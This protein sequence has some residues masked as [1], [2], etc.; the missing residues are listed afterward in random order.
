MK[1]ILV[2]TDFS[3]EADNAMDFAMQLALK[4]DAEIE[5]LHVLE[6]PSGSFSG[7]A[8]VVSSTDTMEEVYTLQLLR[9]VKQ[10]L[11]DREAQIQE[12]GVKVFTKMEKGSV[13]QHIHNHITD[14]DTDLI[15]MG[16]K[17]ATG[18]KEIFV[19]SNTERVIRHSSV[20]VFTVKEKIS[21]D[22]FRNMVFAVGECTDSSI[23]VVKEFQKLLGLNCHLLKIYNTSKM[24]HTHDSAK[25]YIRKFAR[26]T[27]FVDFTVNVADASWVEEGILD[28]VKHN[29]IDMIAMG[30]H[31]YKGLTHFLNGSTAEDVANHA[32]IPVLTMKV[33]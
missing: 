32:N 17:G 9:V 33:N 13:Y 12:A 18:V 29:N 21:L 11:A 2:P 6:L 8:D 5:L 30:T 27:E 25:D 26:N 31:G 1:K 4:T 19:G 28:F 14:Q 20:P 16:S 23:P 15:V 22:N 3:K 24:A 10:S 7:P